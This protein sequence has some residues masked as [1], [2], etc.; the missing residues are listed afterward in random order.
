MIKF[1]KKFAQFNLP[2]FIKFKFINFPNNKFEFVKLNFRSFSEEKENLVS[3][4]NEFL[5]DILVREKINLTK[6]SIN[7]LKY[8]EN[9]FK[10]YEKLCEDS[11][12]IS[13]DISEAP[14]QNE[15]LKNE[16]VRINRQINNYSRDNNYYEEY[17]NILNEIY[18]TEILI[19]EANEIGDDEIKKSAM[20]DLTQLKTQLETLQSEIIEYLIPDQEVI[21]ILIKIYSQP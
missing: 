15:F 18:S 5:S 11:I 21:T 6:L 9:N 19:R 14:E 1:I 2:I 13:Y 7:L 10:S 20:K 16:L 12:K 17:K 8:L 3:E 4:E